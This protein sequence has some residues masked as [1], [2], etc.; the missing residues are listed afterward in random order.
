MIA[1]VDAGLGNLRSVAKALEATGTLQPVRV[2]SD[3]QVVRDADRVVVPGQ[4][5][6][7]DCAS[8]LGPEAPLGRA[9][10]DGIQGGKPYLGICL[11]L[12]VLFESSEESPGHPG[13]GIYRG[14]VRRLPSG[15]RDENDR[16]IKVPH[17]GWSRVAVR[18]THPVLDVPTADNWFYFVHSFHAQPADESLIAAVSAFGS[19][20]VTAAV[21]RDNVVAV[22]YHPEKSQAAG[23]ELL[24][25]F[26]AWRC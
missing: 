19:L 9:I 14:H 12:Q 8:A 24:R 1:I 17:I 25:Q 21:A 2:T 13:L 15:T 11:G 7:G 6:F 26:V 20:P 16:R 10:S 5:A 23:L 18:G 22:Q 4:G 3:P